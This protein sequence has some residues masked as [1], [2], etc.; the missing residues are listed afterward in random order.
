VDASS[1]SGSVC[2]D[3]AVVVDGVDRGVR[4]G[5]GVGV[6]SVT[7]GRPPRRDA[8]ALRR[9]PQRSAWA[10]A[11]GA[12]AS[13]GDGDGDGASIGDGARRRGGGGNK[14]WRKGGGS[15]WLDWELQRLRAAVA[16]IGT[17]DWRAVADAVG[18]DK[19][20]QQ[21][22]YRWSKVLSHGIV[23]GPWT[24]EEDARLAAMVT[25]WLAE[26]R[27]TGVVPATPGAGGGS[28]SAGA[29]ASGGVG[30]S[31]GVAS[32][33]DDSVEASLQWSM[34]AKHLPGRSGKQVCVAVCWILCL[35]S[36]FV[37]RRCPCLSSSSHTDSS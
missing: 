7:G 27:A 13:D 30:S 20:A 12:R 1:D 34:I 6:A 2:S 4:G 29:A 9:Q 11:G 10:R 15:H 37:L 36:L 32:R 31:G 24:S 26:L 23:H 19:T 17:H 33:S 25:A 5:D 28:S 35:A 8:M 21:C 16:D 22:E 3:G 18:G 14:R